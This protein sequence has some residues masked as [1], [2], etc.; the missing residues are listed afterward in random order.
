ME[1]VKYTQTLSL[2]HRD[3]EVVAG[4]PLL[5]KYQAPKLEETKY[6]KKRKGKGEKTWLKWKANN[7]IKIP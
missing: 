7:N 3:R 2:P 6:E 4:R 1:R 5:E